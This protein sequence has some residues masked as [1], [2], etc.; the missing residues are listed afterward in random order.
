MIDFH[1][2]TDSK[3]V[4]M[5]MISDMDEAQIAQLKRLLIELGAMRQDQDSVF[6]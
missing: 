4:V 1:G 3:I 6:H 2:L 5:E